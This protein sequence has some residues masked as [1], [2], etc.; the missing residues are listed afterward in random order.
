MALQ[1]PRATA[2]HFDAL[3]GNQTISEHCQVQIS[4]VR[5]PNHG[6]NRPTEAY[7]VIKHRDTSHRGSFKIPEDGPAPVFD[8]GLLRAGWRVEIGRRQCHSSNNAIAYVALY[9]D[10]NGTSYDMLRPIEQPHGLVW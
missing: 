3:V 9:D 6:G 2:V 8:V 10:V 4:N 5:Y 7:F 1:L